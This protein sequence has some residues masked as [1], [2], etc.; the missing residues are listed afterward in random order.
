MDEALTALR[1]LVAVSE[2]SMSSDFFTLD[3]VIEGATA[4]R[5][6]LNS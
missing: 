4:V 2:V 3:R 5:A 1:P 6:A